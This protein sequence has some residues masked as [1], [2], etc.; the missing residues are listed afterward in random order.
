MRRYQ[1]EYSYDARFKHSSIRGFCETLMA[2]VG[3]A[4]RHVGRSE[5]DVGEYR[6]AIIIDRKTG[7]FL[8]RYHR[9]PDGSI[10][11]TDY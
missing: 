9:R 2:A 8:R 10:M 3:N 7:K 6:A 1:I 4:V 5:F 11:R